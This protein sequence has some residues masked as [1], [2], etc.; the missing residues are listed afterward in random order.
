MMSWIPSIAPSQLVEVKSDN[1]LRRWDK[2]I[3]ISSLKAKSLFRIKMKDYNNVIL[4][5][6]INTDFRI[7]DIIE[8]DEIFYLLEDGAPIIWKMEKINYQ[9][10]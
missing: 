3:L 7:R 6:R 8:N 10:K 4:T 1:E 5:E 2:D 9:N